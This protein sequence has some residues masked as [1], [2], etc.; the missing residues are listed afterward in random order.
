MVCVIWI[1]AKTWFVRLHYIPPVNYC[2]RSVIAGPLHTRSF[3]C[4]REQWR[5]AI[6]PT[7]NVHC[8]QFRLQCSLAN[9]LEWM[10]IY[11]RRDFHSQ[12]SKLVSGLT[13]SESFLTI[14]LMSG[15]VPTC[16]IPLLLDT[17]N[18]PLRNTNKSSNFNHHMLNTIVPFIHSVYI[19]PYITYNF[20]SNKTVSLNAIALWSRK[21]SVHAV[22][23]VTRPL[24]HK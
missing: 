10:F 4:L 5:L 22:E 16:I 13:Q 2:P 14:I 20:R 9:W 18:S 1:N 6:G 24:R 8:M 11:R 3:I 21:G 19:Y 7:P 23:N 12:A 15:F 17:L